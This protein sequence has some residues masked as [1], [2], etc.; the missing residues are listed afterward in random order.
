[1]TTAILGGEKQCCGPCK[2]TLPLESFK[3]DR[4]RPDGRASRCCECRD[5]P[6]PKG[7]G[8]ALARRFEHARLEYFARRIGD[9]E[10]ERSRRELAGWV[11]RNGAVRLERA[12]YGWDRMES[13]MFR[14]VRK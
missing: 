13:E 8:V 6:A 7:E 5:I 10:L 3:A 11:L 14:R 9:A 1:M 12:E 2:R 4:R